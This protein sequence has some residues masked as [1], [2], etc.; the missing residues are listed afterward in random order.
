MLRNGAAAPFGSQLAQAGRRFASKSRSRIPPHTGQR[1]MQP[2]VRSCEICI[3]IRQ[4]F[5]VLFANAGTGK[6]VIRLKRAGDL[7]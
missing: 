3:R 6:A 1:A 5:L 7:I 2:H 4:T